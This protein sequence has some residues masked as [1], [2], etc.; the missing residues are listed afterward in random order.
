VSLCRGTWRR[1]AVH[2]HGGA[3]ERPLGVP[4]SRRVGPYN[5]RKCKGLSSR[6]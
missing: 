4:T 6:W 3:L 2:V 1:R 5:V